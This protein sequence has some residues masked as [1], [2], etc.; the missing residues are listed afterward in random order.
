MVFLSYWNLRAF[1]KLHGH[2]G[3]SFLFQERMFKMKPF[4]IAVLCVVALLVFGFAT[5]ATASKKADLGYNG[6]ILTAAPA[7]SR[8]PARKAVKTYDFPQRVDSHK[9]VYQ[10]QTDGCTDFDTTYAM[11]DGT[12]QSSAFTCSTTEVG[13]FQA[14]SGQF[15]YLSIQNLGN[16]NSSG[17]AT[18]SCII[19]VDGMTFKTVRSSGSHHIASCDG[20]IP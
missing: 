2:S 12:S 5:Y 18:F 14:Q 8:L 6:H 17:S 9:V 10:I 16:Y 15:V 13:H 11:P 1:D 4:L 19:Q 7:K 20:R 3:R